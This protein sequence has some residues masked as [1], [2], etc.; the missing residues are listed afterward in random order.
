V[1]CV[2]LELDVTARFKTSEAVNRA[3]RRALAKEEVREPA[4]PPEAT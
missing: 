3:S 1:N 4:E 2:R